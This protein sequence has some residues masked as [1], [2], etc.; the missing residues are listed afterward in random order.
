MSKLRNWLRSRRILCSRFHRTNTPDASVNV[1]VRKRLRV[2]VFL[3]SSTDRSLRRL[4]FIIHRS[5]LRGF[6]VGGRVG[7]RH[8]L[9]AIESE[10]FLI[11]STRD[12]GRLTEKVEVFAYRGSRNRLSTAKGIVIE[13]IVGIVELIAKAIIRIFKFESIVVVAPSSCQARKGVVSLR[14]ARG[15]RIM[16]VCVEAEE[17]HYCEGLIF[18]YEDV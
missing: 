3:I 16:A 1:Q 10:M 15:C 17:R 2:S 12:L 13:R 6:L 8:G 9:L 18:K 5:I 7:S 11:E 4:G 14:E